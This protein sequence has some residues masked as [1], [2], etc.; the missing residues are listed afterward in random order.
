MHKNS[1]EIVERQKKL[2]VVLRLKPSRGYNLDL[3]EQTYNLYS[4]NPQTPTQQ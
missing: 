1:D 3:D 2:S 4:S